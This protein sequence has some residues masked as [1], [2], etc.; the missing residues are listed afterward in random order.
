MNKRWGPIVWASLVSVAIGVLGALM[1]VERYNTIHGQ[2]R[3]CVGDFSN[4]KVTCPK[5]DYTSVWLILGITEGIA[6]VL[7]LFV[8]IAAAVRVGTRS[9]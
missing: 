5:G 3:P 1:S 9:Q 6:G 2:F 8:I 7:L 4:Y